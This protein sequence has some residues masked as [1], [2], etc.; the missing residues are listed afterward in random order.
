GTDRSDRLAKP[1]PQHR[2]A[3]VSPRLGDAGKAVQLRRG[4][5]AQTTELG[6]Y[7]PDPVP[8]L[9]AAAELVECSTVGMCLGLDKEIEPGWIRVLG[10][11]WLQS[12]LGWLELSQAQTQRSK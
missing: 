10:H 2:V 11:A 9:P 3:Q 6:E 12:V 5:A 1:R 8:R 4:A 7:V